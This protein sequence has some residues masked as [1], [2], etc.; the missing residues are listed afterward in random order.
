MKIFFTLKNYFIQFLYISIKIRYPRDYTIFLRWGIPAWN[1]RR[2][3]AYY[4][5]AERFKTRHTK[6]ASKKRK[7]PSKKVYRICV[8][9][10]RESY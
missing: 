3:V 5:I 2:T 9:L 4:Q 8:N 10:G 1:F 6:C 7:K